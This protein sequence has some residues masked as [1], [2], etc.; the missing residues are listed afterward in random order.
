MRPN[1][2]HYYYNIALEVAKRSTCLRRK[3]GAV[4]VKNDQIISTGYN[5]SPRDTINCDDINSCYREDNNIPSG[6]NYELCL[7]G[8]TEI[9]LDETNIITLEELYNR[10]DYEFKCFAYHKAVDRMVISDAKN[11]RIVKE[12]DELMELEFE[13]GGTLRC[14]PD[15][16][17][18]VANLNKYLEARLIPFNSHIKGGFFRNGIIKSTTVKVVNKKVLNLKD[19]VKVYDL[20]VP[21]YE[22]FAVHVGKSMYIISHNCRSVHAEAN[23]IIHSSREGMIGAT[24]YLAGMSGKD[25]KELEVTDCCLMCKKMIANSGIVNIVT[26]EGNFLRE[27]HVD[28]FKAFINSTFQR[29][30]V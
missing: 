26:N 11:I 1:K 28:T 24:L 15:H 7:T 10:G 5:G 23:A 12:V 30:E 18:L 22:N 9:R 25:N 2:D 19:K 21:A 14:T 4:I 27:T 8:D 3:Y 17:F 13:T 16:K 29:G 6:K 20:T